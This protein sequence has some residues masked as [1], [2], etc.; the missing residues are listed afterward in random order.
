M[1]KTTEMSDRSNLLGRSVRSDE[2]GTSSA[3][4]EAVREQ[5]DGMADV[6]RD[7][8]HQM[9]QRDEALTSLAKKSEA[10]ARSAGAF[11]VR[12]RGTRR[13]MQLDACKLNA[14]LAALVLLVLFL[15]AWWFGLL[16][17]GGAHA[18]DPSTDVAQQTAINTT[19]PSAH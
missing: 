12:A 4:I 2:P 8:L 9:L 19:D 6:M 16:R 1:A 15:L 13:G 14:A 5:V 3:S 17:G 10:T 11:H 18:T 7:N